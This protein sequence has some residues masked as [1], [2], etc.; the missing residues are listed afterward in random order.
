VYTKSG[1]FVWVMLKRIMLLVLSRIVHQL[2]STFIHLIYTKVIG[3]K[4]RNKN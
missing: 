3:A 2:I 4:Q 1:V